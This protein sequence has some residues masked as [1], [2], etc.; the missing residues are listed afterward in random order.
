MG[1]TQ[2]GFDEVR[3]TWSWGAS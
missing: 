1:Q 3:P 2:L